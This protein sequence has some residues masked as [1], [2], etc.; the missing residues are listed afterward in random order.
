MTEEYEIIEEQDAGN[1]ADVIQQCRRELLRLAV[2]G[3]LVV[4]SVG[5]AMASF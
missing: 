3:G 5:Q 4:A 2:I 1:E